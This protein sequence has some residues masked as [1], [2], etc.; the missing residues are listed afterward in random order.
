MLGRAG[1]SL[2]FGWGGWFLCGKGKGSLELLANCLHGVCSWG[3]TVGWGFMGS[4]PG[5]LLQGLEEEVVSKHHA[6]TIPWLP[7]TGGG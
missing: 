7:L 6:D 4:H 3:S 2:V 1:R 5:A